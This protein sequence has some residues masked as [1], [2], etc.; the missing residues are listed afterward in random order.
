MHDYFLKGVMRKGWDQG[1][2]DLSFVDLRQYADTAYRSVD[3]APFGGRLGMVMRANVIAAAIRDIPD[4]DQYQ[5][6]YPSPKGQVFNQHDAV[7]FAKHPKGLII[8]CGYYEDIDARL[9]DCFDFHVFS[10][11]DFVLS[12]G[13]MPAMALTDA[14]LRLL[15]GVLGNQASMHADSFS[16]GL[17]EH[18]QYTK[19]VDF[20]G[21]KV[22]DV[23]LSGHH[24]KIQDW[25]FCQSLRYTLYSR[26]D[27]VAKKSLS[28]K[29]QQVL[30]KI[31]KCEE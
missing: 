18:S 14:V 22:P 26:P 13:E 19:P 7:V 20:E 28:I 8:L 15:P 21:A 31:I 1:C 10:L 4:Y 9:F 16:D 2:F 30:M 23:L 25:K 11:G 6:L 27:L 3:S 29:E 17:L 12:S 24:Q 5:L